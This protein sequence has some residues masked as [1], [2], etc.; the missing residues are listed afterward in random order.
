[1]VDHVSCA[2]YDLQH[3]ALTAAASCSARRLN[4]ILS[5]SP[6]MIVHIAE[7]LDPGG[8]QRRVVAGLQHA[9]DRAG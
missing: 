2:R 4:A 7:I 9:R 8:L 1:M 5:A 6:A 3:D